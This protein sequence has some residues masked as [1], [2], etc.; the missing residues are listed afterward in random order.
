MGGKGRRQQGGRGRAGAAAAG[1][2]ARAAG[3]CGSQLK[4]L[5]GGKGLVWHN[6]GPF[7]ALCNHLQHIPAGWCALCTVFCNTPPLAPSCSVAW[8]CCQ[9][10][11]LLPL[12]PVLS[13][14]PCIFLSKP[15]HQS[16][17]VTHLPR[18]LE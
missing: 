15:P 13:L 10:L 7:A 6:S 4:R 8:C 2:Q 18:G 1:Q 11:Q 14:K 5:F 16:I 12:L 9:A 17:L 3:V